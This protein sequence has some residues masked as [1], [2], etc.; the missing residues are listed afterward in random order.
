MNL[1]IQKVTGAAN[2]MELKGLNPTEKH[3]KNN[4][5]LS[6][7]IEAMPAKQNMSSHL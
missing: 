5:N 6:N 7:N 3:Q 4:K 1:A 2:P